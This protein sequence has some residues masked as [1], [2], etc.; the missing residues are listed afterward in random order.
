MILKKH[1]YEKSTDPSVDIIQ[2]IDK[3]ASPIW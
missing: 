2:N 3:M 1:L